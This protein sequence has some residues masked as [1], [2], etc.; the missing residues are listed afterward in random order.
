MNSKSIINEVLKILFSRMIIVGLLILFQ[1]IIIAL[2]IVK[3]SELFIYLYTIFEVLGIIVVVYILSRKDN[4]SYKLAW[5][6]PVLV[7]PVFGSLLYLLFGGNKIRRK[8]KKQIDEKYSNKL[9]LLNQ[10]ENIIKEIDSMDMS[11]GNQFRYVNNHSLY[12]VYKN[13]NTEYL[14]SG[15]IF[16]EK[17]IEEMKKAKH[18]IFM[19][20][21]II[22]E[23]VMW[24]KILDVL[25]E[26]AKEGLDI[27]V[28]YDDMGCIST[29]PS[30]YNKSLEELGIKAMIFNPVMP[31]LSA[32]LN[33]R[34]H[35]KITIIDGD[36]SFTGGI[37]LADEYINEI[38][39]FGHWKDSALMIKGEAV[40]NF[41][42]MFLHTWILKE[43]IEEDYLKYKPKINYI[44]EFQNDG[45]VQPFGDSPYNDELVSENVYLN[46]INRAKDY[47]YINTPYLIIDN[48]LITALS[49][50]A[51]SGV[52]IR[53]VTPH[54]ADK[55]Y[56]H[57][58]TRA[59]YAQLILAG[60]KI[61]EYTPG[62]IHS[63]T[64]VA[65]DEIGVV[66]TVN[67]DYRSLYLHFECSTL[68]YK[69]KSISRIKNDFLETLDKCQ[70]ITLEDT[71]HIK[72][73]NVILT[74]ILKA[75]SPLL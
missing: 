4:P 44:S 20:Y 22:H 71:K 1:L 12:P 56:V 40:W 39:R 24:S 26:K 47:V 72:W 23:G 18:F 49:L 37:N 30:K 10:D 6:I 2:F 43:E 13:T 65:D 59:N 28:I 70:I 45:Y 3:L 11:I 29:L 16:F 64:F 36:T 63:K 17:L 34:D 14:S 61:Y 66:G 31:V 74:S 60:I 5:I 42:V 48:E 21:F 15:E 7:V 41:T 67:L 75:F 32:V 51:K 73:Y 52:D 54:I 33:N 69:T 27:R 62:F 8:L 35:R 57:M 46:I 50:A 38:T 19:E 25:V 68:L 9:K 55:W 53:I 58:V